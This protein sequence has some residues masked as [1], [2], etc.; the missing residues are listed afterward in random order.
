M[1]EVEGLTEPSKP[2]YFPSVFAPP[3]D[4]SKKEYCLQTAMAIYYQSWQRYQTPFGNLDRNRLIDN[5]MWSNG[6]FDVQAFMG[7]KNDQNR[8]D[9]NPFLKHLDFDPVTVMPKI[10]DIVVG[11]MEQLEFAVTAT[12]VNPL[13]ATDKENKRLQAMAELKGREFAQKMNQAAGREI[14]PKPN[15]QFNSEEEIDTYFQMGGYKP[16]A[17]LQ[18]EVG[19]QIVM[20]DSDWP[21]I[22]KKLCEDAFNC[23][24]LAL[25]TVMTKN[26]RLK[27]K[28][29][30]VINCGVEAYR[31]HYLEQ[32]S[33]IFYIEP[34]S[35]QQLLLD[36]QESG[37]PISHDEAMQ[38]A[39]MYENKYGNPTWNAYN[40]YDAPYV[41]TDNPLG[42]FWY[43]WK[44]PVM[45]V[46]W[47]ELDV[48]KIV[49][50]D[51]FGKTITKPANYTDKT[52]T[53]M[54]TSKGEAVEREK[55]VEDVYLHG[56][57]HA[58]WIP[59]T[60]YMWDYGKVPFQARDPFNP[61]RALCP[62]KYYR[63]TNQ[64]LAERI[65]PH[66]KNIYMA[67]LKLNNEVAYIKPAGFMINIKALENISLGQ[68]KTFTVEHAIE[69]W[70]EKGDIIYADEAIADEYGRTKGKIPVIPIDQRTMI[71]AIRRWI[72]V[73][74]FERA[75]IVEV[76][77]INDFMNAANPNAETPFA[78][79][80]LAQENSQN[81]MSQLLSG[82][83]NLARYAA[84]DTSAR[85]QLI[86]EKFGA[87][88]NPYGDS[89]GRNLL[90]VS[91]VG[92]EI[93]PFRYGIKVSAMPTTQQKLAMKEA[94]RQSF[95]SMSSP[96]QGGLW[97]AD[98]LE[99]EEM[100]DN[101]VPMKLI[102]LMMSLR[103][104]QNMNKIQEQEIE[105][106]KV[107]EETQI[108]ITTNAAKTEIEKLTVAAQIADK[109]YTHKINE[110][111]RFIQSQTL[112]KTENQ[113]V[114]GDAKSQH[115]QVEKMLDAALDTKA[116]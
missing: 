68:G 45:H 12:A 86:V 80:Q 48:Y 24:K 15:N 91:S 41:N 26:G 95:Q 93:I 5:R 54:D 88:D 115:K 69:V 98:M 10:Q 84:L 53:Y 72:E 17:E 116:A 28:Y 32:P 43:Q 11:Y 106:L 73:I 64:P 79:A 110:D 14:A 101:N 38:I 56:Y 103:Q 104:R 108:N 18:I 44:I 71:D 97:V 55:K 1:A 29:V 30:D 8:T 90:G 59:A 21:E 4:K 7:G 52:K 77:G 58:K 47:E 111:I 105:K 78:L 3:A 16:I 83:M 75:Q 96:E 22:K 89:I 37:Q 33:R 66:A 94:I 23:G 39:R 35:V 60:K 82:I 34:M 13:A 9:K 99:F 61:N 65:K 67:A 50:V 25:D 62:L 102:R 92:A 49:S 63:I 57:Y 87:Y 6:Q 113:L 112:Y 19:N 100:V 70:N 85:L 27:Y 36:S 40:Q 74:N 114:T 46:Y 109:S 31:G 51:K 76:T 81:A 107:N 2:S 42:Y 20:N